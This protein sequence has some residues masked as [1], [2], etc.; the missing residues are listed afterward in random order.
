MQDAAKDTAGQ[1]LKTVVDP[2]TKE[3]K[4]VGTGGSEE[5]KRVYKPGGIDVALLETPKP[6]K[7]SKNE[8]SFHE[9][10]MAAVKKSRAKSEASR[11]AMQRAQDEGGSSKDVKD[12]RKKFEDEGGTWASGGRARGGLMKKKKN[13][14]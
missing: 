10:H 3:T 4:T 11:Q 6:K 9:Q 7:K 14:K 2:V 8:P 5:G 12:L 13:K 1:F